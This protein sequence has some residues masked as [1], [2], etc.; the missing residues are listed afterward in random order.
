MGKQAGFF[1]LYTKLQHPVIESIWEISRAAE[2]CIGIPNDFYYMN[3]EELEDALARLK[4]G[5][6]DSQ[7]SLLGDDLLAKIRDGV[8]ILAKWLTSEPWL[9]DV[10]KSDRL[11]ESG[12]KQLQEGGSDLTEFLDLCRPSRAAGSGTASSRW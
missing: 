8:D 1:T 2:D 9:K 10:A 11:L 6:A 7:L 4:S 12:A 3:T 5:L